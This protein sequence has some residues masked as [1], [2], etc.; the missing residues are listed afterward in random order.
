[1]KTAVT[2]R[3]EIVAAVGTVATAVETTAV[4]VGTV[5]AMGTVATTG[6]MAVVGT[7]AAVGTAATMGTLA[8]VKTAAAVAKAPKIFRKGAIITV[9]EETAT[10]ATKI[11]RRGS[12]ASFNKGKKYI[13]INGDVAAFA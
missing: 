1:M 12:V 7:A 3:E 11:S 5:A 10:V 2:V 4:L 13:W 8:A 6:T 9:G